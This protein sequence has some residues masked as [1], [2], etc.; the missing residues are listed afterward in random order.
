MT[1]DKAIRIL[2]ALIDINAGAIRRTTR[3]RSMTEI[4]RNASIQIL[5]DDIEALMLAI[6]SLREHANA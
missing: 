3:K 6:H 1:N 5:R 4:E 2:N